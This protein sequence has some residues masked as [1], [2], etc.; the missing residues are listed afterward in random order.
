MAQDI[1]A[2]HPPDED[3]SACNPNSQHQTW[4]RWVFE[5]RVEGK[6]ALDPAY[7]EIVRTSVAR[8]MR[9]HFGTTAQMRMTVF[10]EA[11][12]LQN[13]TPPAQ[14]IQMPTMRDQPTLWGSR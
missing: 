5:I 6:P 7:Q 1:T 12:D 3:Y 14:S 13:G 2:I 4:S 10:W 9:Q 11:G 8:Y